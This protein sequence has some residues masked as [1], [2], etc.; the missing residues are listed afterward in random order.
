MNACQRGSRAN[1]AR[2]SARVL[3]SGYTHMCETS[4]GWPASVSHTPML[5]EYSSRAGMTSM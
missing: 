4:F 2:T 5:G 3:R 1:F